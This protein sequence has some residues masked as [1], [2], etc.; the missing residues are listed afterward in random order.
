MERATKYKGFYMVL[1]VLIAIVLWVYVGKVVN[2]DES[3][4]VRNL[5]VTFVGA[6]LLESKGLMISSG[7]E[8]KITIRVSGKRN[9]ISAL[10]P[11][12]VSILV[13]V[14]S[15]QEPGPYTLAGQAS[16]NLP[17]T[18]SASSLA[19]TEYFP[20]NITFTVTRQ[21]V[22]TIPIRGNYSFDVP[23]GYQVGAFSFSPE[24]IE[25]RGEE[26]LVNQI[27][28]ALVTLN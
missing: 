27:D 22:R 20:Q 19:V 26:S 12:T 11:D 18:V 15:I 21:A 28:Y 6:D 3:G 7:R 17:G 16:F 13:D 24:V 10:S 4:T 1:S 2:P 5:P 14:S 9:V 25:V 23:D 8:Q